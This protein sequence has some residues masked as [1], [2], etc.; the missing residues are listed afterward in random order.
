MEKL[1]NSIKKI[2]SL[3]ET[4]L[5]FS[6]NPFE[7]TRNTDINNICIEMFEIISGL[8]KEEIKIHIEERN[9]YKTPKVDVRAV[10]FNESKELLLVKEIIDGKWSLPGGW[11]D[12][13]FTP[14]EMAVK[15]TRE[16]SGFIVEPKKLLA[17]MDKRCHD[18]PS[19]LYYIYKIFIACDI[20][21]KGKSAG[22]ETSEIGFFSEQN[23]PELSGPRNTPEQINLLFDFHKGLKTP[24]YFE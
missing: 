23:I 13:G 6:K 24:P 3:A 14:A 15:E 4:G 1:L 18:H 21:K 7:Q 11:A 2:Q 12:I 16:E 17:V 8:K 10:V 19:D 20:V 5:H 9:G 22:L